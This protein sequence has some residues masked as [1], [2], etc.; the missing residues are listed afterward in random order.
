MVA[1][2]IVCAVGAV[3]LAS[4]GSSFHR[5]GSVAAAFFA[6]SVVVLL[7][8]AML[9]VVLTRHAP[10]IATTLALGGVASFAVVPVHYAMVRSG[11]LRAQG[12]MV[13][14]L[15][16]AVLIAVLSFVFSNAFERAAQVWSRTRHR[17]LLIVVAIIV[18]VAAG[19]STFALA[20]G[21][22]PAAAQAAATVGQLA[23][24]LLFAWRVGLFARASQ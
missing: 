9:S 6:L 2:I 8:S 21:G 17:G 14:Y 18:I 23:I 3:V 11:A 7:C 19:I 1:V 12:D 24:G 10:R 15:V 22:S 4:G 13:F 16:A 5:W 20:R